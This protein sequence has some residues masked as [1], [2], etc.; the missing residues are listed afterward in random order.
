[1]FS[2]E[3]VSKVH[4]AKVSRTVGAAPHSPCDLP[5]PRWCQEVEISTVG[6]ILKS[7]SRSFTAPDGSKI[8]PQ[9]RCANI[10]IPEP[11]PL[12]ISSDSDQEACKLDT[13]TPV[14]LH[15][16]APAFPKKVTPRSQSFSPEPEPSP[17]RG[18]EAC[19]LAMPTPPQLQETQS[20]ECLLAAAVEQL[21]AK[22]SLSNWQ[23]ECEQALQAST[24]D[25]QLSPKLQLA[26]ELATVGHGLSGHTTVM[27][28]QIPF[29][30]TQCLLVDEINGDGF[31]GTYDFFY[32]PANARNHGN[33]GFGFISFLS[34]GLADEFYFK[35]H[36]KKF[37]HYE[38]NWPI[39]VIP[40]EVQGFEK[41]VECFF[42]AWQLRRRKC[43]SLQMPVFL[44]PVPARFQPPRSKR[45]FA[46]G[47]LQ[48][49]KHEGSAKA[50]DARSKFC[51]SW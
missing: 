2:K 20:P 6:D 48:S 8:K 23:P 14:K 3:V 38:A 18:E 34:A 7:Y 22:R 5:M 21:V 24:K 28:Q 46:L 49:Q 19:D 50:G 42:S 1:M 16:P 44:K 39:S 11:E 36:G 15:L 25:G 47:H 41:S 35:Y 45:K 10:L 9:P 29:K 26:R 43:Q 40:A 31:E 37:K 4:V 12:P 33:R 30:Y 13:F 17:V 51:Q 27:V 32:L